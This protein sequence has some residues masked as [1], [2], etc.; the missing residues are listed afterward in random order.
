MGCRVLTRAAPPLT[1]VP[2]RFVG[3]GHFLFPPWCIIDKKAVFGARAQKPII[4]SEAMKEFGEIKHQVDDIIKKHAG[5]VREVGVNGKG[6]LDAET[7]LEAY[8]GMLRPDSTRYAKASPQEKEQFD[9]LSKK[10]DS[11]M[12]KIYLSVKAKKENSRDSAGLA[13]F[14]GEMVSLIASVRELQ[15]KPPMIVY[16]RVIKEMAALSAHFQE[17]YQGRLSPEEYRDILGSREQMKGFANEVLCIVVRR[18]IQEKA[19]NAV[20]YY[21]SKAF[22]TKFKTDIFEEV[23]TKENTLVL[24]CIQVKSRR[25]DMQ[26]LQAI[27]AAHTHFFTDILRDI[28]ESGLLSGPDAPKIDFRSF[29]GY[30]ETD[31]NGNSKPGTLQYIDL[32]KTVGVVH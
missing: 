6:S 23:Q 26:D 24:R 8:R 10:V 1:Y 25:P 4:F 13:D 18:R 30:P 2:V 21:S 17:R 7:K 5:D 29:L 28:N 20:A 9:A 16:E 31:E 32:Q 14:Q 11:F 19:G 15:D 22:D 27:H 12:E 3:S